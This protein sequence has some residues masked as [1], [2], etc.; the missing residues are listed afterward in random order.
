MKRP[1][2]KREMERVEEW[3]R[4]NA[5]GTEADV[6]LDDGRMMRTKTRSEAWLMG[7]HT[8]MVMVEGISGAYR[9]DRVTKVERQTPAPSIGSN[10]GCD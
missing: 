5:V 6:R 10:Q 4:L 3:N 9:L 1:N 2:P 7:G 8:A